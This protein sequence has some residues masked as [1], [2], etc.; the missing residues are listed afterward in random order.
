MVGRRSLM[1]SGLKRP[2]TGPPLQVHFHDG[3][4]WCDD[5]GDAGDGAYVKDDVDDDDDDDDAKDQHQV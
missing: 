4:L 3:I 2:L 1:R 5:P